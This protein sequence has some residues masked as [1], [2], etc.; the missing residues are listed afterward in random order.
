[1]SWDDKIRDASVGALVVSESNEYPFLASPRKRRSPRGR[2]RPFRR[3][4][5]YRSDQPRSTSC[6]GT[7]AVGRGVGGGRAQ[8]RTSD[9]SKA[10][11]PQVK[12]QVT[13]DCVGVDYRRATR[14]F[15]FSLFKIDLRAS[16]IERYAWTELD[17]VYV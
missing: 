14:T 7:A 10:E 2:P 1:M 16:T 8:G 13:G 11:E 9:W 6:S 5:L 17:R 12:I 4:D 15:V 3:N